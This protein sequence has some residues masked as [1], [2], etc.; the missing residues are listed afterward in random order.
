MSNL[1]KIL[2]SIILLCI[3]TFFFINYKSKSSYSITN[4]MININMQ[5][6][7]V[8]LPNLNEIDDLNKLAD[9]ILL[10][11]IKSGNF[12]IDKYLTDK[13]IIGDIF[14]SENP[15]NYRLYGTYFPISCRA[16]CR[17]LHS[18]GIYY[19]LLLLKPLN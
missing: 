10:T 2:I 12:S 11:M 1:T 3:C 9:E 17:T 7:Y 19:T 15:I 8:G 13:S 5:R 4:S 6:R 14:I 18:N 16:A